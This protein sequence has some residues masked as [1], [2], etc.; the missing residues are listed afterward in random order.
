MRASTLMI[1]L[2]PAL[3][4][5]MGRA[6]EPAKP[7]PFP[8]SS[9]EKRSIEGWTVHV[10]KAL[11]GER[12]ELGGKALRLLEVK[13]YEVKRTVPATALR[14]L[15]EV[16]IWL[17]VNDGHA[18]CAE[19]HWNRDWL[20]DNG[21]NPDKARAVEIGNAALFLEW[22][23]DQPMMVLHEL[24]HAYHD[25]VLG[26]GHAGIK[27]AYENAVKSGDYQSV[28]SHTG[29]I[30]KAY[31]LVNDREYFAEATEAFF[32]TN[33]MFPF[34]RVELERHDPKLYQILKDVWGRDS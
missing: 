17:G 10:N 34:V 23:K 9:Y 11:L 6:D 32:G 25:R 4:S 3:L 12:S 21:Y 27:S 2:A 19:Y 29:K 5:T 33:D 28:L 7:R 24:S 8:T 14:K 22:S 16:P 15:Q 18:P 20:V 1:L 13:L 31:A 30:Q 26:R